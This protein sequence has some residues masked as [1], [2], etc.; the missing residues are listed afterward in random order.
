[1]A[2]TFL[3]KAGFI[4]QVAPGLYILL[5]LGFRVWRKIRAIVWDLMED[6]DVQNL[7]L[8]ILIILFSKIMQEV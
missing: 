3:L 4:K 2:Y 5:P 1:M 6:H 7:Q 8:P